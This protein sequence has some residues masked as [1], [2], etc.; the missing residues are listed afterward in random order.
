MNTRIKTTNITM[1]PAIS[2]FVDT[3]MEKIAKFLAGDSTAMADVDLARTTEHHHKGDIFKADIHVVAKGI[4]AY[5]SSENADLYAAIGEAKN[6][7]LAELTG[8]QG[9]RI[10]VVRRGGAKVKA[11]VKGLWPF[12]KK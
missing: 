4:D 1:S 12:S 3:R 5:A 8:A 11:M 9:K 7:I 2:E 10:S 6:E